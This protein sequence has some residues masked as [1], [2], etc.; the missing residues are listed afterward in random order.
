MGIQYKNV[1]WLW[2]SLAVIILDQ[3][4]K[5]IVFTQLGLYEVVPLF[6]QLNLTHMHNTGAAFSLLS[7]ASPIFFILLGVAVSVGILWW[8]RKTPQGQTLVCAALVL[9]QGGAL[10][11]VID[12][13]ARGYVI[14][15]IDFHVAGWHWPAFNVADSAICVGAALLLLDMMRQRPQTG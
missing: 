12:R 9:I 13:A 8:L 14:D 11:N 15:F 5:Q 10:G 7:K 6:S 3:V 1:Y 4:S 2:L